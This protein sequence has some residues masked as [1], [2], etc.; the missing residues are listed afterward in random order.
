MK[1]GGRYDCREGGCD[2]CHGGGDVK[3]GAGERDD[4]LAEGEELRGDGVVDAAVD[5]LAGEAEDTGG[6][7]GGGALVDADGCGRDENS[8]RHSPGYQS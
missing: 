7:G 5:L 8:R 1:E 4:G 3:K 2:G 6:G